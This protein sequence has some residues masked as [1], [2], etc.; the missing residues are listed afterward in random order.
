MNKQ[1]L[2]LLKHL[3]RGMG[4]KSA[5][6]PVDSYNQ[7]GTEIPEHDSEPG[8]VFDCVN[9]P[10]YDCEEYVDR[11]GARCSKCT[12]RTTERFLIDIR[13][14]CSFSRNRGRDAEFVQGIEPWNGRK[15]L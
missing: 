10:I 1:V 13:S 2:T 3:G 6:H 7:Y 4:G 8:D 5:P 12:V 9:K 15:V 11:A 14:E